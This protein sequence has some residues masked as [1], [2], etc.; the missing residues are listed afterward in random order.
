MRIRLN[1]IYNKAHQRS[2][3]YAEDVIS[4][5]VIQ[6]EDLIIDNLV[7]LELIKKYNPNGVP[8]SSSCC[9]KQTLPPVLPPVTIQVKNAIVAGSKVVSNVLQGKQ[10]KAS[11]EVIKQRREIC[12]SCEFWIKESERCQLCGCFTNVKTTLQSEHCPKSKW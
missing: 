5:G 9:G 3:G 2:E 6:G 1:D 10:V 12:Q 4:K 8:Q 7:Y 11:D